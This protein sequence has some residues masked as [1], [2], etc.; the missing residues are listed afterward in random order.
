MVVSCCASE[1]GATLES[2]FFLPINNNK[3]VI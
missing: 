2:R 1:I 3:S